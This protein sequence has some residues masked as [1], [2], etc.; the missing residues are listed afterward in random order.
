MGLS[1]IEL[2][3]DEKIAG[4]RGSSWIWRILSGMMLGI[5]GMLGQIRTRIEEMT[6]C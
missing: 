5:G 3:M 4:L 1:I 2:M 6:F